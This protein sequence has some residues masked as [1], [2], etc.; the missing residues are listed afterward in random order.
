MDFWDNDWI[1]GFEILRYQQRGS[2]GK[3]VLIERKLDLE[4]KI[5]QPL[6]IQKYVLLYSVVNITFVKPT[7]SSQDRKQPPD[8]L[9]F[10]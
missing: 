10:V 4:Q 9:C 8:R 3:N 6:L 1:Q 5:Q 7:D 2:D